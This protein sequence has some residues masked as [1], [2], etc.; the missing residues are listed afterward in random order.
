MNEFDRDAQMAPAFT[1]RF[2]SCSIVAFR[3]AEG[4][5]SVHG[6]IF[7]DRLSTINAPNYRARPNDHGD[8]KRSRS[9]FGE[10]KKKKKKPVFV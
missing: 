10:S 5:G 9:K 7:I 4:M 3:H 6:R 8:F 2:R 1:L